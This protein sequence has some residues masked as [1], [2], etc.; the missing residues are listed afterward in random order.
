[1]WYIIS[2][3][4]TSTARATQSVIWIIL[5]I[6]KQYI[7]RT[8]CLKGKCGVEETFYTK[9]EVRYDHYHLLLGEHTSHPTDEV[10]YD[11]YPP[12]PGQHTSHTTEDVRYDYYPPLLGEHTCY[13]T[14]EVRYDHYHPLL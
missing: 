6:V 9:E 10:R 12:L 2:N 14:D 1:M 7:D 11:Y 4:E 5:I 13:T 3:V 8:K